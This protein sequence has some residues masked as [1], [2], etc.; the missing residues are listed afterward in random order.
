MKRTDFIQVIKLRSIWKVDKR[1]GNYELP[2]GTRLSMYLERLIRG[3]MELDNIRIAEDG[4][5]YDAFEEEIEGENFLGY[6]IM[7]PF[8][9]N[10]ICTFDD[11]ETRIHNLIGEMLF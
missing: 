2:N 9:D 7:K 10:E 6:K 1:K 4:N 8:A 3:Q 5:L 11:Q